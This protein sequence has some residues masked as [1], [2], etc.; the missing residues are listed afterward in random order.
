[1][2]PDLGLS[3]ITW[4]TWPI[5]AEVVLGLG[6][7]KTTPGGTD[8]LE[9]RKADLYT[10]GGSLANDPT[11]ALAGIGL[12]VSDVKGQ[13]WVDQLTGALVKATLDYK[14]QATGSQ[15]ANPPTGDGHLEITVTKI[16]QV[17]VNDPNK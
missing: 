11:G 15:G 10:L 6:T 5:N 7:L 16:G 13:V 9:D 3:A 12:P 1:M 14:A 4:S 2:T 8:T 17:T